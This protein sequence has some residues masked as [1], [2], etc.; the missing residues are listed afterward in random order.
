MMRWGDVFFKDV[1]PSRHSKLQDFNGIIRIGTD[2]VWSQLTIDD[3]TDSG[4]QRLF[5]EKMGDATFNQ[6]LN[7]AKKYCV[8]Q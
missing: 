3:D 8:N 5:S 6:L 4:F 1:G 7:K 2:T